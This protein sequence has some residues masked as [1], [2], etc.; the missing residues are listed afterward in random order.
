M[1][2]CGR[3]TLATSGEQLA[4]QFALAEAPQLAPRYNIAPTQPIA[5]V[6]ATDGGRELVLLRWGLVPVWANDPSIGSRMINARAE[7]AA[8]KPAFRTA[9]RRRRCLIPADGFYEWQTLPSGKQPFYFHRGDGAPFAFA[10]LWEHWNSPDG[11]PLESC[12]ILTTA[13]NELLRPIHDRMPVIIDPA[14]YARWLDPGLHDPAALEDLLAPHDD[15][16]MAAHPVSRAVNRVA[17][18]GP[19]LIAPAG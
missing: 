17:N 12:T 7:T 15:A 18:D 19:A 5:V 3:F 9:M 11:T 6:R 14:D 4:T 13:A 1:F 2:M 8:V 10:G 16:A